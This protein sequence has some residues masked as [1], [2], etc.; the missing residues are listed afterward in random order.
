MKRAVLWALAATIIFATLSITP[1][2][3][4]ERDRALNIC[5][6][7]YKLSKIHDCECWADAFIARKPTLG[8]AGNYDMHVINAIQAQCRKTNSLDQLYAVC[9]Q[10]P[11]IKNATME[12]YCGCQVEELKAIQI[13]AGKGTNVTD[14]NMTDTAEAR[15]RCDKKYDPPRQTTKP[16]IAEHWKKKASDFEFKKA[17]NEGY[18]VCTDHG[19]TAGQSAEKTRMRQYVKSYCPS[20]KAVLSSN[21]IT[22][23]DRII[24]NVLQIENNISKTYSSEISTYPQ[25]WKSAVKLC[26]AMLGE[27]CQKTC[28][29][30]RAKT[31]RPT[32]GCG[33]RFWPA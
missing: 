14:Y 28:D 33:T 23:Q 11:Q 4:S 5:K 21:P 12:T 18:A 16:S 19:I 1:A 20:I 27:G 25:T 26:E 30:N 13:A 9:M 31:G 17:I 24:N 22:N 8:E 15:R 2:K 29:E 10:E 3:A 6:T 32:C 7:D